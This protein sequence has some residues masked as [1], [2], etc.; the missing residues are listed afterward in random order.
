VARIGTESRFGSPAVVRRRS[1]FKELGERDGALCRLRD[2]PPRYERK[3]ARKHGASPDQDR[4]HQDEHGPETGPGL[5]V[6]PAH[7]RA[8]RNAHEPK[9]E[10]PDDSLDDREPAADLDPSA[11]RR[12]TPSRTS[13]S[14]RAL[15]LEHSM[16]RRSRSSFNR[17][18]STKRAC[19]TL[20]VNANPAS[21]D[22]RP[23]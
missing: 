11:K 18:T 23:Q 8:E 6:H 16:L 14:G 9:C 17:G 1:P 7:E 12:A 5:A 10:P 4:V 2:R 15:Q 20:V 19:G 21:I 22:R 13:V 3:R